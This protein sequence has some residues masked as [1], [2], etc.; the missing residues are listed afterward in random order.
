M[1]QR[2]VRFPLLA[3]VTTLVV[4][5][6]VTG[7]VGAEFLGREELVKLPEFRLA[8]EGI[9]EVA[10]FTVTNTLLSAWLTTIVI[11]LVFALGTRRMERVPG[12]FQGLLESFV[13][14]LYGF[15]TGVAGE[16]YGRRF[17]PVL[18]TIF[19]FVAFNAWIALLPIYPTVF[20]EG[21]DGAHLGP[22]LRSAGTDINM[23]LAL[24]IVS[25]I[26]VESWGFRAH[27]LGYMREFVRLG[28]ILQGVRRLSPGD[29]FAGA[30]DA[31]V[32]FLEAVSHGI[33]VISFTFRLFGNMLAGELILLMVTF[34][35]TFLVS[36]PF[37]GLE[38]LVGGVQALIFTG[39]TLVFAV[40]AV[41]SHREEHEEEAHEPSEAQEGHPAPVTA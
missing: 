8:P 6:F 11:V 31:F 13:V 23:P 37:Y 24:A 3:A 10:G 27:G 22:L 2:K 28:G 34:L 19:V 26:F 18:A 29:I 21:Q 25:A 33:R 39:L 30:I 40:M 5:G 7:K 35:V 38:L 9:F 14:A 15:V 12:R 17:F 16:R 1:N 20:A 4:V 32:G 41:A 36:I